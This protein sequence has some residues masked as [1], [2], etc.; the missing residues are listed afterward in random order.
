MILLFQWSPHFLID[1]K[2]TDDYFYMVTVHTGLRPGSGTKANVF[3]ILAGEANET[4][5]RILADGHSKVNG[6]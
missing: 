4:D 6:L 1:N 2:K 3:F 5:T